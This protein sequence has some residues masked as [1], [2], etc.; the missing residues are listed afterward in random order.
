MTSL[1]KGHAFCV[2]FILGGVHNY[3]IPTKTS[4]LFRGI[5]DVGAVLIPKAQLGH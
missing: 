1:N 5:E 2:S 4:R 3:R